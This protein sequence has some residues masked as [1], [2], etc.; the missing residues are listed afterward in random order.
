MIRVMLRRQFIYRPFL[1]SSVSKPFAGIS[2]AFR[3]YELAGEFLP[4]QRDRLFELTPTDAARRFIK[5]FSAQYFPLNN[6]DAAYDYDRKS[7]A[8]RLSES[9]SVEYRGMQRWNYEARSYNKM[10]LSQLLAETVC[11]CP[12]KGAD[13]RIA[14]LEEFRNVL[15][16]TDAQPLIELLPPKGFELAEVVRALEDSPWPGLAAKAGWVFGK[17]GNVWLDRTGSSSGLM[18]NNGLKWRRATVTRVANDWREYQELDKQMKAF[19]S[20]LGHDTAARCGQ[21]VRYIAAKVKG[22][23]PPKTL[24]EIFTEENSD[25]SKE[26]LKTI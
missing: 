16:F 20:W 26:T 19:E 15:G 1:L 6:S 24:A 3:L 21:V 9:I 17:T 22:E 5:S 8:E 10:P 25:G 2:H 7:L 18:N 23:L 13:D 4:E 11:V 12:F 14:V